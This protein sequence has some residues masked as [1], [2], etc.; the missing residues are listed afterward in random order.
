MRR[1]SIAVLLSSALAGLVPVAA[2][3]QS[4]PQ[5]AWGK[6]DL[7][8]VWD[9]RSLTPMERPEQFA[10]GQ[11]LRLGVALVRKTGCRLTAGEHTRR[12]PARR[13]PR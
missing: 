7:Q 6:P 12:P 11:E 3:A 10:A 9:F 13:C 4:V 8:G 5:T 2:G 1:F